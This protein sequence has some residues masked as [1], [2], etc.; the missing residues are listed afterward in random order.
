MRH[1]HVRLVSVFTLAAAAAACA[2][3]FG[4]KT[5][6]NDV[7][8]P[9]P[10][11][12]FG[13]TT[14]AIAAPPA[15]SGGTLTLLKGAS[16]AA[17]ADADRDLVTLTALDTKTVTTIALQKGDEPGRIAQDGALQVHVVLRGAGAVATIDAKSGALVARRSVCPVPRGIDFDASN[18]RMVVACA[19]GE[20]VS[21][22]T[23]ATQPATVAMTLDR[24]LRDVVVLPTGIA[25]STF[26]S[27]GVVM[28]DT[29]L[30]GEQPTTIGPPSSGLVV[31]WRIRGNGSNVEMMAQSPGDSTGAISTGPGGYTQH[32][33]NG[34]GGTFVGGGT[35]TGKAVPE[36]GTAIPASTSNSAESTGGEPVP[37]TSQ[38]R[39]GIS[40][41]V[42]TMV[43]NDGNSSSF[44]LP[45]STVVLPIDFARNAATGEHVIVSAGNGHTPDLA[46]LVRVSAETL[47]DNPFGCVVE[48]SFLPIDR[49]A[50]VPIAVD[51]DATGQLVVQTREPAALVTYDSAYKITGTIALA[52]DSHEDTGH[53]IFHSN[54][55][56]FIACASCHAEGG[57]DGHT[58]TF[59]DVGQR[60]TQNLRGGVMARAPFHWDGSIPD[61][62]SLSAQVLHERMSGPTLTDDQVSALGHWLDTIPLLATPTVV[63]PASVARGAAIFASPTAQCTTCHTGPQ[64][65]NNTSADVGTGQAF[66]VPTLR[67]LA[68]RAP[69]LHTGCAQTLSDRFDATCGGASHGGAVDPSSVPD[70]IA[71]LETL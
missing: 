7:P 70:L 31:A 9:G 23:D 38:C 2:G 60:R 14:E 62:K 59:A 12:D 29:A 25:V 6:P 20:I 64:L 50:G 21:L 67:G 33:G 65:T 71:Y 52:S 68:Y 26:R 46:S 32:G 47:V 49:P 4:A 18:A 1:S 22:P 8:P 53:T 69:Y 63:D 10:R 56:G 54:A 58:W 66:Q 35:T 42:M 16:I 30:T 55:G 44:D 37:V 39:L 28:L 3:Q 48:D 45:L 17:A 57:D 11:P 41:A 34:G 13:A 24:D 43:V 51:F 5:D 19:G 61:L 40:A 15:L 27:A 36:Q